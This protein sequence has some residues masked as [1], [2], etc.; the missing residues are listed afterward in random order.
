MTT[1]CFPFHASPMT[2]PVSPGTP[3]ERGFLIWGDG[4][5]DRWFAM[6]YCNRA[7]WQWSR[8]TL[9]NPDKVCYNSN[10]LALA[11]CINPVIPA[12]GT[13]MQQ[14]NSQIQEA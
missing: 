1:A 12:A 10:W 3:E 14:G 4:I 13:G 2:P 11:Y 6:V 7:K 9:A 5:G 8:Q